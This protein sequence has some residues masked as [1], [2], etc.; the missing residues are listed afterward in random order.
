[1]QKQKYLKRNFTLNTIDGIVFFL[2]MIFLSM[3]SVIPVFLSELGASHFW[4]SLIPA[5]RNIGVFFPSIFVARRIQG[6]VRQKAWLIKAGLLQRLPWLFSGLF[7]YFFAA[8]HPQAAIFSIILALF[9][10]NVG[11]GIS[12]PSYTYYTAKTIPVSLRGRLFALRN[13]LSYFIGFLCG[14]FITWVLINIAFPRNYSI[15]I[16]MGFGIMMI[17]LPAFYFQVEPDA[18]KTVSRTEESSRDFFRHLGQLMKNNRDLRNYVIARMFFTL[19]FASNNYFAVYLVNKFDLPGSIVGLITI[20]TA[21]TFLVVNPILGI[22][23][24][25]KGHLFNHYMASLALIAA[26]LIAIFSSSYIVSLSIIVLGASAF[27]IQNVSCFAL[28]MEFCDEHEIPVYIG[29]VGLFVGGASLLI[30]GFAVVAESFGY[31]PVFV[32]C[33]V[34]SVISLIYFL[35]TNE[36]RNRVNV[37]IKDA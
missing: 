16:L 33:L 24:D 17:Y 32:I 9:L 21:A 2:G 22:F 36:P 28:P 11:A 14:A 3:E 10:I 30:I 34:C 19:A 23:S 12:I 6:L 25:K 20:L 5:I 29:L 26:S 13:L 18:K 37:I 35:K 27:C 31:I 8:T 7:C 1:M 4:I 15:L